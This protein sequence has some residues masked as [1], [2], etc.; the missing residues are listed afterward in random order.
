MNRFLMTGSLFSLIF[1]FLLSLFLWMK[2][3]SVLRNAYETAMQNLQETAGRKHKENRQRVISR[4][5][6][7]QQD[8]NGL[9]E[10]LEKRLLY[11]GLSVRF[12]LLTTYVWLGIRIVL[13]A[14][15]Y[16]CGCLFQ[17]SFMK[18]ALLIMAIQC[19]LY[20]WENMLMQ[21]NFNRTED[22][23]LKFLDCL[24]S[25]SV[26]TSELTWIF[27]QISE[28]MEE[29]VKGVLEQCC[30][31]AQTTGDCSIALLYMAEKLEHPKFRELIRNLEISIRYSADLT[32]LTA[33]SR[34]SIG[35]YMRM[36]QERKALGREAWVNMLILGGMTL[37]ILKAVEALVGV[38]MNQ[39][40]FETI[41]GKICIGAVCLIMFLFYRQVSVLDA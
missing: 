33:Q 13:G 28:Y 4:N 18:C 35:E 12:P 39:I 31:E 24:G 21:N 14:V 38:P 19:L 34:K 26:T 41:P 25:Y 1:L 16:L 37:V 2:E 22:S 27:G 9:W 40:L 32:V 17:L 15:T 23:L 8:K 7:L 3:K 10:R 6:F 11:S 30:L 29:P 20:M 36:R 5:A